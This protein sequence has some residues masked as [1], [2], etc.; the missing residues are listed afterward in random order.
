MDGVAWRAT[1]HRVS[2]ESDA[3]EVTTHVNTGIDLLKSVL[4]FSAEIHPG[5]VAGSYGNSIFRFLRT[6][7][8]SHSGC[9]CL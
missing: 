9:T 6:T 8:V 3:A 7:I 2:K 4:S 5:V 1:V